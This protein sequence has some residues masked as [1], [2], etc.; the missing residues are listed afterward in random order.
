V[1]VGV[2]FVLACVLAFLSFVKVGP[3][4]LTYRQQETWMSSA[5]VLVQSQIADPVQLAQN[6][7]ALAT[8]DEVAKAAVRKHGTLGTLQAEAGYINRTSTSLPTVSVSAISATPANSAVLANDSISALRAFIERQQT[9]AGI[10]PTKRDQLEILNR[11]RPFAALVATPRSKTPPVI[12][13]VLV[14][15]ATIGLAFL[16]ENLR[17]RVRAVQPAELERRRASNEAR[18][19]RRQA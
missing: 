6:Y 1:I 18:R 13:F 19:V 12:V 11:A 10:P 5:R 3:N 14:V 17:P 9:E 16:L 4:G 15:A 7:A 2:G 8:S